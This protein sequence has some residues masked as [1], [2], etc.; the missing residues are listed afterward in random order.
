MLQYKYDGG[1]DN[2]SQFQSGI[3]KEAHLLIADES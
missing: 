2:T 1:V 3:F